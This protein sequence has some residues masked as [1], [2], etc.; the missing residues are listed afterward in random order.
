MMAL[1]SKWKGGD[2]ESL[3][4]MLDSFAILAVVFFSVRNDSLRRGIPETGLFATREELDGPRKTW[5][6]RMAGERTAGERTGR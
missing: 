4:F 6:E 1:N 5:R 2:V 3:M